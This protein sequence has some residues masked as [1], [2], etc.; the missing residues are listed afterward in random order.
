M[1]KYYSWAIAQK[2]L[3]Y[4]PGGNKI[5]YGLGALVQKNKKGRAGPMSSAINLV[6]NIQNLVDKD[7]VIMDVG[8]G[9]YHHEPFLLYLCGFSK[10]YLFDVV[11]KSK[12]IYIKNYLNGI[13]DNI[14]MISNELQIDE[15]NAID[16][17]NELLSCNSKK[18][19][20]KI[21]NF[22]TVITKDTSSLFLP[23]NS[24]DLM[25]SN[26][27]LNHI[28][29]DILKP[30][31][32]ILRKILKPNGYMHFLIGHDD[33]WT[34]HDLKM[35]KFQYYIYSDK[36]YKRLFETNFQFQNRLVKKELIDLFD[37]CGLILTNYFE[38]KNDSSRAEI[39][40][41]IHKLDSRFSKYSIDDLSIIHSYL[42]LQK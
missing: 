18:E 14:E 6:K 40:K 7:A 34:F 16:K 17:I 28:P 42:T 19:I 24:I 39:E 36:Y 15:S 35:N 30:E 25:V 38:H 32:K 3:S 4:V 29:L 26:C 13:V 12:F 5:Y 2:V 10:F 9:W 23:E 20:Y 33:H 22:E 41:I 8:T 11:E 31:L 21:C 1:V 37:Q 27:V